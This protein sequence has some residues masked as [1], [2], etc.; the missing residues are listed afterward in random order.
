MSGVGVQVSSSYGGALAV[1]DTLLEVVEP[2]AFFKV[3]NGGPKVLD[4]IIGFGGEGIPAGKKAPGKVWII[5]RPSFTAATVT[6]ILANREDAHRENLPP[7]VHMEFSR[8]QKSQTCLDSHFLWVGS[9]CE[10]RAN[11]ETFCLLSGDSF[12]IKTPKADVSASLDSIKGRSSATF[13]FDK[14]RDMIV[15]RF[16]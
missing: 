16:V 4:Y 3:D 13:R 14:P 9:G 2:V 7:T 6:L 8:H 11:N 12:T 10:V 5:H 1:G 15:K